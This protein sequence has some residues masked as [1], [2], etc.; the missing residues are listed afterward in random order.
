[1][2]HEE[3]LREKYGLPHPLPDEQSPQLAVIAARES[4][5]TGTGNI[6]IELS[7]LRWPLNLLF[8]QI[9][10]QHQRS[11]CQTLRTASTAFSSNGCAPG[12]G[13]GRG[14]QTPGQASGTQQPLA[15]PSTPREARPSVSIED[16]I[17]QSMQENCESR[18]KNRTSFR[19]L[20]RDTTQLKHEAKEARRITDKALVNSEETRKQVTSLEARVAKLETQGAAAFAN[21][22]RSSTSASPNTICWVVKGGI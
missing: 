20:R 5:A 22:T 18:D 9:N 16:L 15:I 14:N 3:D 1:M 19:E 8:Q 10:F 13:Q 12:K 6:F 2:Q 4:P 17:R 7:T 11:P 21:A